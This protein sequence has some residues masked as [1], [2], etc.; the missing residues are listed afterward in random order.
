MLLF[1]SPYS[2]FQFTMVFH[3][4]HRFIFMG[5]DG[6]CADG[7]LNAAPGGTAIK[8]NKDVEFKVIF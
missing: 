2:E 5:N 7:N 8:L 3:F 1:F 4:Q 6:T